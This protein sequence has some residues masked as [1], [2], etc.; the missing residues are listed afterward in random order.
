MNEQIMDSSYKKLVTDLSEAIKQQ[1]L[2]IFVN[3]SLSS[4][5]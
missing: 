4:G 2:V 5:Q 1:K 3:S